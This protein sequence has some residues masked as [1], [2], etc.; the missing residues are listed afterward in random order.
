MHKDS[1]VDLLHIYDPK[2]TVSSV[3]LG[4][5]YLPSFIYIRIKNKTVYINVWVDNVSVDI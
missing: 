2:Q 3:Y 4:T 1:S 5:K